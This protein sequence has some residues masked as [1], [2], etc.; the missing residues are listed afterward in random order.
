M[1]DV[2]VDPRKHPAIKVFAGITALAAI[3]GAA[4]LIGSSVESQRASEDV[5][6]S[7]RELQ[8]SM[9]SFYRN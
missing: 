5:E 1:L 2:I 7:L 4:D 9:E 3:V 8:K 6:R